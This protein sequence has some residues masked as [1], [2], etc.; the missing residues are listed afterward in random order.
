[1]AGHEIRCCLQILK[2]I[3]EW[4]P[5]WRLD[6]CDNADETLFHRFCDCNASLSIWSC[7][8]VRKPQQFF[9][10]NNW[11]SWLATNLTK[12]EYG[13]EESYWH[14]VFGV[15][16]DHIWENRNNGSFPRSVLLF[17]LLWSESG[18]QLLQLPST[19][20]KSRYC[21]PLFLNTQTSWLLMGNYL[22]QRSG[23]SIAMEPWER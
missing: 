16:L 11:N 22:P 18:T 5:I 3:G 8:N 20:T 7:F 19:S 21:V 4:W 12:T 9:S 14:I 13:E 6:V 15:A 17:K 2:G 1:M 23:A 10:S